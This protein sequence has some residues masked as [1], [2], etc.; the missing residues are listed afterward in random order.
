[1]NTPMANEHPFQHLFE[2]LGRIPTFHSESVN[3]QAYEVLSDI[4]T[5]PVEKPGRCILLRAPRAGHGKTHLLSRIQHQLGASH[6]FIPLHAS[7][8]CRIDAATVIDDT[9]RRLVR[10]LPASGGL[11]VLD[12]VTRRLFASALQPL[13]SSGEV[14]CQDREGALAALRMRPIETFDFHHPNAVTAHWARENFEVLGQRLGLELAQR[15]ALPV[16]EVSFWVDLLFRFAAAPLENTA[17]VRL[18]AEAAHAGATEEI[19]RLEALLGLLA[20]L[21]RVVLIADDLEGFSTDETAALRLAAFLG[22]LRQS[23]DRLDVVLSLNQDIWQSAFVPRLSGGLADRLSE[24]VVE[25]EPLKESEMAELLDSR[26]PGLGGRVLE[27]IDRGSAGT[28]AR[29]LIR[30]AGL[31]WLKATAMDSA[32]AAEVEA[33]APPSPAVE[34][35]LPPVLPIA[36]P[37]EPLPLAEPVAE[38][39]AEVATEPAAEMGVE[40]PEAAPEAAFHARAEAF[41]ASAP[42]FQ[43]PPEDVPA[44]TP[45]PE[46]FASFEKEEEII[47]APAAAIEDSAPETA[48]AFTFSSEAVPPP[49]APVS[50][51]VPEFSPPPPVSSVESAAGLDAPVPEAPVD[52]PFS[53]EP[54]P[55]YP[56]PANPFNPTEAPVVLSPNAWEPPASSTSRYLPPVESKDLWDLDE[57]LNT[58]PPAVPFQ[59]P[60]ALPETSPFQAFQAAAEPTTPA[61]PAEEAVDASAFSFEP[62]PE[63]VAAEATVQPAAA[64]T[65]PAWQESPPVFNPPS[66]AFQPAPEFAAAAPSP[67]EAAT[68][69][70]QAVPATAPSYFEAPP[71]ASPFQMAPEPVEPPPLPPAAS[72]FQPAVEFAQ[73]AAAFEFAG[74]P[75]APAASPFQAFQPF[76]TAAAEPAPAVPA[77]QAAPEA[78][79]E[80]PAESAPP[81][82][83]DTDRVD[84]LLKQFRDRYGRG[85]L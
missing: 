17:R 15:A 53:I 67:F 42:A 16:R 41:Q 51:P 72:P 26:V 13:V 83:S 55:S 71:A 63:P 2:T 84:D 58:A 62:A 64:F 47:E 66:Q 32:P 57:D 39:A 35:P 85:S 78:P 33:P 18:L 21:M 34:T 24:V 1:M 43:A 68:A 19:E 61:A 80:K 54:T 3:R 10:Q 30:A 12:L 7:F 37:S 5:V 82:Q 27:K 14:P 46:P 77:F 25:L 70:A 4:L 69:P 65:P 76:Q 49:E 28:H 23:V 20:Q 73:P 6:E 59:A 38:V 52:S 45:E 50:W 48:S 40:V 56:A 44:L 60:A 22:Q 81:A 75:A 9:L 74:Q 31:A 79:P 8:G 36:F 29:G 11:C